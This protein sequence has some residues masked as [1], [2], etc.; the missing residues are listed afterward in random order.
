MDEVVR[1]VS[2]LVGA[3]VTLFRANAGAWNADFGVTAMIVEI[4]PLTR[5]PRGFR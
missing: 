3:P 2:R 4:G 1:G 5:E